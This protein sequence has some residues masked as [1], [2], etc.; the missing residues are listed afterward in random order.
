MASLFQTIDVIEEVRRPV[1]MAVAERS[2]SVDTTLQLMSKVCW[3]IREVKT[4]HNQYVDILL[5]VSWLDRTR[6]ENNSIKISWIMNL[7][8]P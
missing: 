2:V 7:S 5:R 1:L 4:L 6:Q 8:K 3:D